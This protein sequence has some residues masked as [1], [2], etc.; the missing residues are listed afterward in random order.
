V[1]ATEEHNQWGGGEIG[2]AVTMLASRREEV[3]GLAL[4]GRGGRSRSGPS[5]SRLG[6]EVGQLAESD[7]L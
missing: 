3:V 4:R 1:A 5:L 7:P 6:T 2:A